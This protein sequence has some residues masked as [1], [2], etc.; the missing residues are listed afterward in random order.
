M[1]VMLVV[2][3]A[4][5]ACLRV[6]KQRT[7]VNTFSNTTSLTHIF[8]ALE[9]SVN[10]L[11]EVYRRI[12]AN[13]HKQII[14]SLRT[15]SYRMW[16]LSEILYRCSLLLISLQLAF[17]SGSCCRWLSFTIDR[18]R[19]F[20][21]TAMS[22]EK[23]TR[24]AMRNFSLIVVLKFLLSVLGL[25]FSVGAKAT[26]IVVVKMTPAIARIYNTAFNNECIDVGSVRLKHDMH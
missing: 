12:D 13:T 21:V 19:V 18:R 2:P 17:T 7:A 6:S 15:N 14:P 4:M 3:L 5:R 20:S 24:P 23:A 22:T 8:V 16:A 1:V 26:V 10:I 11:L 25:F 9:K